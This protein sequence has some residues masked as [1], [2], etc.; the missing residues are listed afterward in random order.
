MLRAAAA[1]EPVFSIASRRLIFPGPTATTSPEMMRIRNR[2]AGLVIEDLERA[3]GMSNYSTSVSQLVCLILKSS[4]SAIARTQCLLRP[5]AEVRRPAS[6]Q[7]SINDT[8]CE[9]PQGEMGL[10][11]NTSSAI[12]FETERPCFTS[13]G[14]TSRAMP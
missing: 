11:V 14:K 1:S 6:T 8:R 4:A 5:V 2:T 12:K 7:F 13:P 3:G 10:A 9:N